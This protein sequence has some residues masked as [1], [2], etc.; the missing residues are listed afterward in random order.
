M[1]E[2]NNLPDT[3]KITLK[4]NENGFGLWIIYIMELMWK[5]VSYKFFMITWLIQILVSKP[6]LRDPNIK[7]REIGSI[8]S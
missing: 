7:T 5:E 4:Q 8:D 1:S 3:A 6:Q 2:A